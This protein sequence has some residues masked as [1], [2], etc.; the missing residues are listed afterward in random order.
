MAIVHITASADADLDR[1]AEFPDIGAPRPKLG[2]L[3]R[4]GIVLPYVAI[5]EHKEDV[6]TVLRVL[7]GR[8]KITARLIR[9]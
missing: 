1:L 8:R 4:V 6:V 3:T 5:Y 9:L 2:S 7:H